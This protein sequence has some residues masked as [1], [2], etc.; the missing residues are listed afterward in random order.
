MKTLN[1]LLLE[2]EVLDVY[3]VRK[4]LERSGMEFNMEVAG[5]RAEFIHAITGNVFDAILADNAVPQF[6]ALEALQLLKD[7]NI[8]APFILVTGT[9]TEEFAVQ[10]MKAGA[11]DFIVK[12]RLQRLP[13][14]VMSA[15]EKHELDKER[16][17]FLDEVVAKE[18]FMKEAE[19]LARFGSF[20]S[21]RLR[22][23]S[24][25][26]DEK[27][28]ILG[29]APG[30]VEPSYA[31]F[32]TRIHPG[33][34]ER[35]KGIHEYGFANLERFAYSFRIITPQGE[36]KHIN[37]E[38]AIKRDE[39][40]V[41]E[42]LNGF[43]RDVTE[44]KQAE[45]QILESERKYRQLF[46]NNPF[47]LMVFD[48]NTYEF[49]DVNEGA[50]RQY[51]YSR[52][53]F[54]KMTALDIRPVEDKFQFLGLDRSGNAGF[55]N[56]G[57]WK[58]LHKDGGIFDVEIH[59]DEVIFEGRKARLALINDITEKVKVEHDLRQSEAHLMAS[60]RIGHIGGWELDLSN[61]DDITA[62]QLTW[63]AETFNIFG[64][65]PDGVTVTPSLFFSL[66]HPADLPAVLAAVTASLATGSECSV[67]HRIIR[68]DG[69]QRIVHKLGEVITDKNGRP[70]KMT[71]TVQDITERKQ[72]EE[73]LQK[74]EANLRT[75]FDN[76]STGYALL[77]LDLNVVSF[78]K[79]ISKFAEEQLDK[80]IFE[81][82]NAIDYFSDDTKDGVRRSLHIA[83]KG[84]SSHYDVRFPQPDGYD[85]WYH[86][87]YHP[88]YDGSKKVLGVI[89]SVTDITERKISELQEKK[90]TADLLQRNNDLE[91]FAYI[92]SHN[93]RAPV[94]NIIGVSEILLHDSVTSEEKTEFML[95]L[96]NAVKKLDGVI[97]DLN[98]ILQVKYNF[99]ENKEVVLFSHIVDDIR[100]SISSFIEQEFVELTCDFSEI[101]ELSTL[102]SYMH[103]IFYNLIS[104][105]IKYR[106]PD[107]APVITIESRRSGQS[108]ELVFRD[109]G[110]GIDMDKKGDEVF[111]LYKRFH[112]HAAEGK[113][114]GLY[115]VKTQV[116]TLGGKISVT[117]DVDKGSEFRIVFE[118]PEFSG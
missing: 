29:Y 3:L 94:T 95:A 59:A 114:I 2:D 17:K 42:Y 106:R 99:R 1:L 77:D 76:T 6:S 5:D 52:E 15:V 73:L 74:S 20:Q 31:N 38:V 40:H 13:G 24:N 110:M 21:D 34:L 117:S 28:R 69:T 33:D 8:I 70:V 92:I 87:S 103:S 118:S 107:L 43:L 12:D 105:S 91:Q 60:Q 72:A 109:N 113:G 93:L 71:G 116:E 11:G 101:D 30:E 80:K 85:K 57:K 41:V 89:M 62:N 54:L 81:H 39:K 67:E 4:V 32:M 111:G 64:F 23:V 84:S 16:K 98:D 14:A 86:A 25:W 19:R 36:E 100:F 53:E 97:I 27:Y 44:S 112:P 9:V 46:E 55:A 49:L 90:I 96:N 108:V 48:I 88:V 61:L 26:S 37:A 65:E 7:R 83:L 56:K 66:I 78:N 22:N 104:N 10:I 45:T 51:G 75:I 18:A 115:M 102:K 82:T 79:P 50:V 63:T 68:G 58:H 35:V 47:P